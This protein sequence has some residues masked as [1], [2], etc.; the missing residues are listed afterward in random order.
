MSS[1]AKQVDFKLASWAITGSLNMIYFGFSMGIYNVMFAPLSHYVFALPPQEHAFYNS[2]LNSTLC[3]GV[4]VGCVYSGKSSMEQGRLKNLII[5]DMI[6]IAAETLTQVGHVQIEL[7]ARLLKGFSLGFSATIVFLTE[8]A[9]PKFVEATVMLGQFNITLAFLV[10]FAM[11]VV[12]QGTLAEYWHFWMF[13]PAIF[14]IARFFLLRWVF[15][16]ET[17][18]FELV[19][20]SPA[21]AKQIAEQFYAKE[22]V[23]EVMDYSEKESRKYSGKDLTLSDLLS[24][25]YIGN[26]VAGI[27]LTTFQQLSGITGV[28]LY[29]TEGIFKKISNTPENWTLVMGFVNFFATLGCLA[30]LSRVGKRNFLIWG[31]IIQALSLVA[32]TVTSP[33][34][35]QLVFYVN[36]YVFGFAIGLGGVYFSYIGELLP[37]T[38]IGYCCLL[39]WLG[40]LLMSAFFPG[41][42]QLYGIRTCFG[43]F[44]FSCVMAVGFIVGFLPEKKDK[45]GPDAKPAAKKYSVASSATEETSGNDGNQENGIELCKEV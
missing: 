18:T 31:T 15:P 36:S 11:G 33:G 5:S 6:A 23:P 16:F 17:P 25:K 2:L 32:L 20:G 10:C 19:K 1:T 27:A 3:I 4:M 43:F 21:K 9:H 39:Q 28:V 44:A 12:P 37:A 22:Y 35:N 7:L 41:A 34:P 45:E 40:S 8:A 30:L 14:P 24:K 42:I 29:S 13:I 26:F 38:G